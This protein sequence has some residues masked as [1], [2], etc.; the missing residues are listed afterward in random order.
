LQPFLT[1]MVRI[2]AGTFT[3]GTDKEGRGDGPAH[4]VKITK[5]FYID[6]NEVTQDVYAACVDEGSCTA[7]KNVHAGETIESNWGCN[8]LKDTPRHPANCVDREQAEKFCGYASKRLPTEAEWEYAA[9]GTDGREYPWGNNPPTTCTMSA[10]LGMA[11]EC[12]ERKGTSE[13]GHTVDGRSPFGALDM[14]G[15]VWEWVSDGYEPYPSAEVSDPSVALT[16]QTRGVL[17]G[18]SWDYAPTSAKTTYRLPFQA[19]IGNISTGFRC[20]RD[21]HD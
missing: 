12:R 21:A 10:L 16:P 19:N 5:A 1:D 14:S 11:G 18:G 8:T 20:A 6:R 17:R 9:R 15:N 2:P 13:V 4:K 7:N 3:M